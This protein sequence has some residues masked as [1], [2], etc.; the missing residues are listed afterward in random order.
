[1]IVVIEMHSVEVERGQPEAR[2]PDP[3]GRRAVLRWDESLPE[4]YLGHE[5]DEAGGALLYDCTSLKRPTVLLW[6][7]SARTTTHGGIRAEVVKDSLGRVAVVWREGFA[8]HEV[9]LDE[10]VLDSLPT[11]VLA[12]FG[13]AGSSR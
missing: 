11:N 3:D 6:R 12:L 2:L 7:G 8:A 13:Q 5:I 4:T 10:I 9:P 1:M